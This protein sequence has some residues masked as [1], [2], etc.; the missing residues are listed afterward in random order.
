[1]R[2]FG[3]L[4]PSNENQDFAGQRVFYGGWGG[5]S[6][7]R[8]P[9]DPITRDEALSRVSYYV[10]DYDDNGRLVQFDKFL[11]GE[12]EWGDTY[13]Y[14]GDGKPNQRIARMASGEKSVTDLDGSGSS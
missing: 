11:E 12:F 6:F 3:W 13:T 2:L 7:P 10:A 14:F 5:Y 8:K 9:Q 4:R 1:M